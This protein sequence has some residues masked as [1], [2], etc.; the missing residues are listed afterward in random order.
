MLEVIIKW[1]CPYHLWISSK[2]SYPSIC[3][4][5]SYFEKKYVGQWNMVKPKRNTVSLRFNASSQMILPLDFL[6]LIIPNN[7]CPVCPL[8]RTLEM[9][10]RSK[11]IEEGRS[12][13]KILGLGRGKMWFCWYYLCIKRCLHLWISSLFVW[14]Q[15]TLN[16]FWIWKFNKN[17]PLICNLY[18]RWM[19]AV[20]FAW[21]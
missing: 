10:T 11:R 16:W 19:H 5:V 15:L 1:C 6:S 12:W 7:L 17:C 2:L 13:D 8:S 14:V 20:I 3:Y 9:D 4:W 18:Y 21:T